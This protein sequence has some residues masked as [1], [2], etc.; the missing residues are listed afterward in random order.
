MPKYVVYRTLK[1]YISATDIEDALD[2]A[3]DLDDS[4][5]DYFG[6]DVDSDGDY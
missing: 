2:I 4:D 3:D 6:T 5:F 1:A